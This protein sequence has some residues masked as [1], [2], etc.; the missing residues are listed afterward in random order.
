MIV[1]QLKS[2]KG[3]TNDNLDFDFS[4][5][6]SSIILVCLET[7]S[8]NDIPVSQNPF[9]INDGNIINKNNNIEH[10]IVPISAEIK[11]AKPSINS[12][13]IDAP[14][15]IAI[16]ANPKTMNMIDTILIISNEFV[17]IFFKLIS[18][19]YL[20]IFYFFNLINYIKKIFQW[21]N[22]NQYKIVVLSLMQ[23][24]II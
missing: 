3:F 1:I 23:W 18:P 19:F 13:A 5:L 8:E 17:G 10:I 11:V 15:N 6:I 22:I 20:K 12:A 9:I 21:V 2:S 16:G 4:V 7:C 14:N 24:Q